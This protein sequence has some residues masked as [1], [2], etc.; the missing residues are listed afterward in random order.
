MFFNTERMWKKVND[1]KIKTE[2]LN[3]FNSFPLFLSFFLNLPIFLF[4]KTFELEKIMDENKTINYKK[5]VV[6]L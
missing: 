1:N 5:H 6:E 2:I 3:I 4:N